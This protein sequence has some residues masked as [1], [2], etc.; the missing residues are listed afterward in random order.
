[1][2]ALTSTCPICFTEAP[3]YT[4]DQLRDY[5]HCSCDLIFVAR[6]SVLDPQDEKTR[7]LSHENT[8][9][10]PRY[11]SYLEKTVNAVTPLLGERRRGLDFGCGAST[12]L[13]KIFEERGYRVDSYDL[14]F[15]PSDHIWG[16]KYDF[17]VMSE[18]I[19]HLREPFEELARLRR[20]LTSQ[21]IIFI[22]TMYHPGEKGLFE[23]WFYKRDPTHIQFFNESSMA[24]LAS[25][26]D[27]KGGHPT[28]LKDLV[29]I[30]D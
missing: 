2:M 25:R 17:I 20:L 4:S 1:M 14:Y 23:E 30:I 28:A 27:L 16:N 8:E 26:I 21:G 19:E 18:V 12:L 9:S 22:K 6:N 7:Y 5:F 13:Q 11:R 10:D 29:Y 24:C 3:F 15:H